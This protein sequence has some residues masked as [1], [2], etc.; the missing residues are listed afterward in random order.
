MFN[1]FSPE[2]SIYLSFCD[3]NLL[4]VLFVDTKGDLNIYYQSGD[5]QNSKATP[6]CCSTPIVPGTK[7]EK[8]SYNINEWVG[9]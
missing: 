8:P 2:L 6:G 3:L 5:Q 4:D 1:P 7:P 9:K